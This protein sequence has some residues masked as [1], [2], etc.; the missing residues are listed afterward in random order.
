MESG[1][2]TGERVESGHKTGERVESGHETS[3]RVESGHE[4]RGMNTTVV[5]SILSWCALL[6]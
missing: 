5:I 1:H 2:E 4:T 3:E 6:Q